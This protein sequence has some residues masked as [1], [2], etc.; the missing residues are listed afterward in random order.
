LKDVHLA[1]T[2]PVDTKDENKRVEYRR[3]NVLEARDTA[4]Q[5]IIAINNNEYN[6]NDFITLQIIFDQVIVI[7]SN[8]DVFTER[9]CHHAL[10]VVKERCFPLFWDGQRCY[11]D[12]AHQ[13]AQKQTNDSATFLC[14]NDQFLPE[15]FDNVFAWKGV[16]KPRDVSV[17]NDLVHSRIVLLGGM[18]LG[19]SSFINMLLGRWLTNDD[20]P[21]NFHSSRVTNLRSQLSLFIL[22]DSI[23]I[24]VDTPGLLGYT[25]N[26]R[27]LFSVENR[28]NEELYIGEAKSARSERFNT[29]PKRPKIDKYKHRCG[30]KAQKY[31]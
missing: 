6:L 31:R 29:L 27:V 7:L 10:T 3:A 25:V 4:A 13:T 16:Y 12:N 2:N 9:L 1:R 24:E 19:N 22:D 17:T 11:L 18:G 21:C 28:S 15:N 8:R 26:G 30:P 14:N 20:N 23:T 5:F